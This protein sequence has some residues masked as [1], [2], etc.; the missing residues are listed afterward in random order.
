MRVIMTK[1]LGSR[2]PRWKEHAVLV[3]FGDGDQV[4]QPHPAHP[5][6]WADHVSFF[7][8][9]REGLIGVLKDLL[10]ALGARSL[11]VNAKT[12][13]GNAIVP[14]QPRC[15]LG[16]GLLEPSREMC[17]LGVAMGPQRQ[18][19]PGLRNPV[20]VQAVAKRHALRR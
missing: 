3:M 6:V 12:T 7:P 11:T 9:T 17:V 15:S 2:L 14:H 1:V 4:G 13:S 19:S 5:F 18:S 10:V 20:F 8:N 16:G